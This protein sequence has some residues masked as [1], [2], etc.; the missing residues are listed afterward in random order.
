MDSS[1]RIPGPPP[2]KVARIVRALKLGATHELAAKAGGIH[3][4]TFYQWLAYAREGRRD[5]QAFADA[6][7]EA[8]AW[9]AEQA[10]ACIVKAAQN[11]QW[12]AGAWLLERRWG[13]VRKERVMVEQLG[14]ADAE[15]SAQDVA[16]ALDED[17]AL[18]PVDTLARAL[19]EA[20]QRQGMASAEAK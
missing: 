7:D 17:L 6:V 10:L 16:A 1:K 15:M 18:L 4:R 20:Q 3:R 11:N 19:V 14:E 8:E 9:S 12:Q 5:Y 13:Y 2:A